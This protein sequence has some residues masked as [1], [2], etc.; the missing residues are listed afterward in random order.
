MP[1]FSTALMRRVIVMSG[2]LLTATF[3]AIAAP[4]TITA[5]LSEA[6]RKLWHADIS[7]PVQPGAVTLTA[8]KWIPGTHMPSGPIDNITGVIFRANGQTLAWRR[9]DVGLY[10]FHVTVP[11]GVSTLDVHLDAIVTARVS[12]NLAMLEWEKLM[13]YPAGTP[14]RDIQIQPSIKVPSGWG[15][16]TALTPT[17]TDGSTTHF[18]PVT[19]EMLEDSPILTGK[20]FKEIP[21]APDVTPKHFLDVAGDAPADIELRPQFLTAVNN[22]V[23]EAGA[24]Y[25]SHHYNSY[26]FLLTL[27]DFAG[28]EGLE[29]HQSS[30]NGVGEKGFADDEHALVE[31]DLLPH[32]FTHSWNG[33]F[34]RPAGLATPDYATPMQGELLWVYEGMTEYLGDVL[35][36]RSG[37][38][39]PDQ[40]REDL[41]FTAASLDNRPGRTWR[42]TEDTAVAASIL[43]G[44][45]PAWSNWRRGQD[46]YQEGELLWLDVD[47][48]IRQLTHDKKSLHDFLVLF[49]GKGGDTVPMV[50]PYTFDELAK[51]LNEVVPYDWAGFLHERITT[52]NPHANLAGIEHGGYRLVYTDTPTSYE[53]AILSMS[54]NIDGWFSAGLRIRSDGTI[55]DVRVYSAAD[56]AKFAPGQKILAVN[57]R[58]FSADT[59]RDALKQAKGRQEPIHF[60]VQSDTYIYPI[61]LNYHEGEKYPKFQRIEGS[62]A[63]LDDILKPMTAVQPVT[64]AKK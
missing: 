58:I 44:G 34:R 27:S 41:A 16:G 10:A 50:V 62:P 24:M 51:T 15:I 57:G 25:S 63:L 48:T 38:R 18:A 7:I 53:R 14:V 42:N 21:L 13:L 6:S 3:S 2:L 26:H 9:D 30:D 8:A 52:L 1:R 47:T 59:F 40:Y 31:A 55:S 37:F 32:E 20:Y 11:P 45:N 49:V 43:R 54:G 19:L 12:D 4:I 56:E 35:A 5:D 46:Y 64:A 39:T 28:G 17:G 29:H 23:H 60:I 61:D 22:L 33:K 36:A